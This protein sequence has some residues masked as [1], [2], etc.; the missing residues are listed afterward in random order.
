MKNLFATLAMLLAF[1]GLAQA[2]T[3]IDEIVKD[4]ERAKA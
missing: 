2:Q 3:S 1:I 4:W